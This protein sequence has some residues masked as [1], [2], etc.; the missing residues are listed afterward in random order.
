MNGPLPPL[1]ARQ[2]CQAWNRK[3]NLKGRAV[4]VGESAA[5]TD[6]WT[7]AIAGAAFALSVVSLLWQ[8]R[9]SGFERP[10]VSVS[11][12]Y[13]VWLDTRILAEGV[14][15]WEVQVT[16]TKVGERPV[17]VTDA[18]ADLDFPGGPNRWASTPDTPFPWRP[19]A[20]GSALVRATYRVGKKGLEPAP[21]ARPGP[22]LS[23]AL[24]FAEA[25]GRRHDDTTGGPPRSPN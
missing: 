20:Y 6:Q 12:A 1:K 17:T 18:G 4:S 21:T 3:W 15:V 19:E 2:R 10:I 24:T 8:V 5:S 22:S 23:V 9:R 7:I 14:S 16:L 25:S 13:K 11:A